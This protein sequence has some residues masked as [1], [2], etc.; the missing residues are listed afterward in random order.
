MG[1]SN[2]WPPAGA[3]RVTVTVC[4]ALTESSAVAWVADRE[5]GA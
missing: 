5:G 3:P 1:I 2:A 4:G